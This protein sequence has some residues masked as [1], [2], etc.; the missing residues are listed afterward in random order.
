M[1]AATR[2]FETLQAFKTNP[3]SGK[4]PQ[5]SMLDYCSNNLGGIER[6]HFDFKEKSQA[7]R[8]ELDKDDKRNLGK[9]IS[10]FA[11]GSG[12][13]LI[14]GIKDSSI[15][16]RPISRIPEFIDCILQMAHQITDPPVPRIDGDFVPS[17]ESADSGFGFILIPESELPP[18]RVVLSLGREQNHYY[19]RTGS[20]FVIATHTQLEDMFGRRPRP[21]LVLTYDKAPGRPPDTQFVMSMIISIQNIGR[22]LAKYPFLSLE[23]DPPHVLSGYGL[24]GNGHFGLPVIEETSHVKHGL[25]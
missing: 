15:D 12:G 7:S 20:S 25:W 14:W 11:N 18:H 16:P 4:S 23:V 22:G 24:D 19:T 21:K 2:L 10:G 5:Q 17:D 8:P 3:E 6:N 9:A 1:D 13:V